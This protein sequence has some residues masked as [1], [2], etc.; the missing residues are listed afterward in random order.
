[1]KAI[2]I[3]SKELLRLAKNLIAGSNFNGEFHYDKMKNEIRISLAD[4]NAVNDFIKTPEYKEMESWFLNAEGRGRDF[5][6][7]NGMATA[8]F[9]LNKDDENTK[10]H[11]GEI[12]NNLKNLG[13]KE[14]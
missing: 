8:E 14:K 10:S 6:K 12:K 2:R 1:M 3:A 11:I 7:K 4:E 9:A 5:T 13:L